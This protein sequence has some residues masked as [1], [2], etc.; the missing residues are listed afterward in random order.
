MLSNN[1]N[2]NNDNMSDNPHSS[3]KDGKRKAKAQPEQSDEPT[4]SQQ[5]RPVRRVKLTSQAT[6]VPPGGSMASSGATGSGS[7]SAGGSASTNVGA[8]NVPI[9]A[10]NVAASGGG[11]FTKIPDASHPPMPSPVT[12]QAWFEPSSDTE[13]LGKNVVEAMREQAEEKEKRRLAKGKF[14]AVEEPDRKEAPVVPA[15]AESSDKAAVKNEPFK[16]APTGAVWAFL[17]DGELRGQPSGY[18]AGSSSASC[19]VTGSVYTV[20]SGAPLK[21]S[22]EDFPG[23]PDGKGRSLKESQASASSLPAPISSPND[24]PRAP[25]V[26]PSPSKGSQKASRVEKKVCGLPPEEK[27]EEALLTL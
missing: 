13:G 8:S 5:S 21:S 9:A 10:G 26:A 3:M 1:N 12:S 6:I 15:K 20:Q 22:S 11:V 27:V 7:A 17:R 2:N 24:V 19:P 14:K 16:P 25:P 4:S 18:P 23:Q